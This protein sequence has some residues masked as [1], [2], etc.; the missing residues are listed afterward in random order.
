MA[1]C[2]SVI[3]ALKPI[4]S[5]AYWRSM[6]WLRSSRTWRAIS[7]VAHATMPPSPEVMFLVG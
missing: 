7:S 6:P 1:A 5:L 3:R 2:T 4:T